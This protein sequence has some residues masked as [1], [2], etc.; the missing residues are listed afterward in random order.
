MSCVMRR[1]GQGRWPRG[2]STHATTIQ[3][4]EDGTKRAACKAERN[5]Q[6][7]DR[8]QI[9]IIHVYAIKRLVGGGLGR[10]I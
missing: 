6:V 5:K 4:E 3:L 10:I 2:Q 7:Q 9:I 8:A 1:R